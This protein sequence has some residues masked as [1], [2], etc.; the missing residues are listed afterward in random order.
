MLLLP[1]FIQSMLTFV[2]YLTTRKSMEF[3]R[4]TWSEKYYSAFITSEKSVFYYF[5][6]ETHPGAFSIV[7]RLQSKALMLKHYFELQDIRI[8]IWME[9]TGNYFRMKNIRKKWFSIGH[10]SG[11]S[12]YFD[13]LYSEVRVVSKLKPASESLL[14]R[15]S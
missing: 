4:W 8:C 10:F 12:Y 11:L 3:V 15:L 1:F 7:S 6:R 13:H 2:I 5:V 14:N 9:A